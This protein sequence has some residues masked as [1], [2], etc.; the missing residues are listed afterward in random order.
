MIGAMTDDLAAVAAG[1]GA[2]LRRAGLP[3]GMGRSERFAAAVTLVRPSTRR[4]L[5]DCALATLVSSKDQADLL[6]A[7]F[8]E[9]FGPLTE[10]G[11]DSDGSANGT[12]RRGAEQ[13][14]ESAGSEADHARAHAI[15]VQSVRAQDGADSEPDS[16]QEISRPYLGSPA[17]RLAGTDF[18]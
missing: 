11:L 1:F 8:E 14:P 7:V 17:E 3:V 10:S 16:D 18:A 4:E 5:L 2:A 9:V 13:R 15:A 6:R 12:D